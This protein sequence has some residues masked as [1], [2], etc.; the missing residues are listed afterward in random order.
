MGGVA[1]S[2]KVHQCYTKCELNAP[3]D[4]FCDGYYSGYDTPESN[5]ICGDVQLCQYICDQFEGC[6]S[7]DMHVEKPRCFLN[8]VGCGTHTL[9][10]SPVLTRPMRSGSPGR[11]CCAS[12]ASASR[13]AEDSRFASATAR[14]T[15]PASSHPITAWSSAKY[16]FPGCPAWS[17]TRG[18]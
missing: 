2:V 3:G 12:R 10:R 7:I 5:A 16:T 8:L 6:G 15:R 17:R 4:Q 1:Q 18:C 14:S 9:C 13:V 11:R